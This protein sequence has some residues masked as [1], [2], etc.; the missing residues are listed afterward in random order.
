[1]S[2]SMQKVYTFMLRTTHILHLYRVNHTAPDSAIALMAFLIKRNKV[3]LYDA[4]IRNGHVSYNYIKKAL[5]LDHK[6]HGLQ[7]NPSKME[8]PLCKA[9]VKG[10]ISCAP[11]QKE[12]IFN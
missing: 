4:H 5:N 6:Y 3:S 2:S 11:I 10:K 8:E 12:H 1:M 7:I 9:C